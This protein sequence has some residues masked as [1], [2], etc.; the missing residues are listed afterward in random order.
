MLEE[1]N[2]ESIEDEIDQKHQHLETKKDLESRHRL[3]L[4]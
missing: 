1:K 3:T 4:R 2:G